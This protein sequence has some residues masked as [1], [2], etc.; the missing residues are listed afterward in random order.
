[1]HIHYNMNPQLV[2]NEAEVQETLDLYKRSGIRTIWL[3]GYFFGRWW[4]PMADMIKAKEILLR[5]GFEVGV[6]QVPVGHPGNS[7]NPDDDTL[8]LSIPSRWRYRVGRDGKPV[9]FCAD[10]DDTMQGDNVRAIEML[11]DAGF[12]QIFYDDDLRQGNWG[13]SIEGCFCDDCLK[14]YNEAYNRRLSREALVR[15]L[16]GPD[17][18]G[19]SNIAQEWVE[20][21]CG[22]IS[23]L[24]NRS[25]LQGVR[26]GLQVMHLGD[27]RHGIDVPGIRDANPGCM[28]RVGEGH[29]NDADFGNPQAR[30]YDL[31]SVLHFLN[32]VPREQA[33]SETT[34]FPP[35]R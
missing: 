10:L 5:N 35:D 8:D 30:A 26:I 19:D 9:Y 24:M 20:Y 7:L 25:N 18:P 23:R 33:F 15:S 32:L 1:M 29:F 14:A 13:P 21:L 22:K 16:P 6:A 2:I 34:V 17:E 27:E 4:A 3:W 31:F 28:F 12:E 11:R